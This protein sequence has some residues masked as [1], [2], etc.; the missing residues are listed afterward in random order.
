MLMAL[1][2]IEDRFNRRLKYPYVLLTDSATNMTEELS[3][4]IGWITEGRATIGK[5]LTSLADSASAHP[6][7][8]HSAPAG[9]D[10]GRSG[11]VR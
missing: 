2:N 7:W 3:E 1:K 9:R 5:F 11:W 6:T 10:V 4:K 8:N